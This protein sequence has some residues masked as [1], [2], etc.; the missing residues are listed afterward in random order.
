L[1]IKYSVLRASIRLKIAANVI[2][3]AAGNTPH[4][5]NQKGPIPLSNVALFLWFLNIVLDTAGH[6][7]FKSAA[8]T[9]HDTES[10]RWKKMLSAF[11]FWLGAACFC[12]EFVVWYGL[13]SL[14]PLSLAVMIGSINIVAV[15]LAGRVLFGESLDRMRVTGM[16][17]ICVGVALAGG[18]A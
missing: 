16:S 6:L 3:V 11:P 9:E 12:I 18:Y 7:S 8:I 1:A 14:V 17:L 10:H 5:D 2:C 4:G 13:L 15:M